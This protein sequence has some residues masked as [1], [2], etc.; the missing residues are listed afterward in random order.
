MGGALKK[1]IV[2]VVE[3]VFLYPLVD[4]ITGFGQ[5]SELTMIQHLFTSYGSIEKI[6]LEENEVKMMGTYDP[7]EPLSRLI[8]KL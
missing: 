2:T 7:T 1:N 3:P 6:N 5:L 4:Q 8:E